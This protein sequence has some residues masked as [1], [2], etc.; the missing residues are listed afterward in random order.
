MICGRVELSGG[1]CCGAASLCAVAVEVVS[2][3]SMRVLI[4]TSLPESFFF[5]LSSSSSLSATLLFSFIFVCV[6]II[7]ANVLSL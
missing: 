4:L 6:R 1:C 7:H 2:R 3:H 5:V